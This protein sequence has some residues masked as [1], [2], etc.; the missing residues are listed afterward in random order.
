MDNSAYN[1]LRSN[2]INGDIFDTQ[3][4]RIVLDWD[5]AEALSDIII[6]SGNLYTDFFAWDY[7]YIW[8]TGSD[9]IG[10]LSSTTDTT[11]DYP[12]EWY[13]PGDFDAGDTCKV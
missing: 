9:S 6:G 8:S 3:V 7:S 13:G 1:R 2:V 10:D 5:Y 11:V 12:G 4:E